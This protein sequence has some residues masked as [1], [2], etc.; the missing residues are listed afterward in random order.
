[1]RLAALPR[2]IGLVAFANVCLAPFMFAVVTRSEWILLCLVWMGLGLASTMAGRGGTPPD[3]PTAGP[4]I[5]RALL[6]VHL[7]I[8]LQLLPMPAPLLRVLSPGAFAVH[9]L[10][11][12]GDGRFRP[13]SV[14][15]TATVDAWVYI[16]GLQGLFLAL[17]GLPVP[18]R[19]SLAYALLGVML[20]L[21]GE[22]LWQSRSAHPYWLLGRVPVAVPSGFETSIFGPYLNRNH[23]ATVV[24]MGAGLAAGLAMTLAREHRGLVRLLSAPAAVPRVILLAGASGFLALASAASG[25]RSGTLAAVTAMAIVVARGAGKRSLLIAMGL[26]IPALV[27]TGAAAIDRGLS[28]DLVASRFRPWQDMTTLF[29]FFPVFG[30]GVGTFALAYLPYQTNATYEIWPHAHNDYLQWLI[31]GGGAGV[32]AI[33]FALR[34]LR[35]SVVLT[36]AA[37]EIALGAAIAF[38]TQAFLDFPCRV[39][40]NAAI[41]VCVLALTTSSRDR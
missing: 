33:G 38:A 17:Q 8:A 16:A 5:S 30:S 40:A 13:I 20:I 32:V 26:G 22:G 12:P 29:R 11:D 3:P 34:S 25:S 18:R 31:E 19:R 15:S 39:P 36:T 37:R 9:F 27:L 23:F 4:A 41:L 35:G 7:L 24:A 2:V 21:A 6:P 14:S 10:P 1:M 28:V